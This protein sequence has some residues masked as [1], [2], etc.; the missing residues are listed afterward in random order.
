MTRPKI[1][2][3]ASW[4]NLLNLNHVVAGMWWTWNILVIWY[5]G[6]SQ[7]SM[8]SIIYYCILIMRCLQVAQIHLK[9]P[10]FSVDLLYFVIDISNIGKGTEFFC[11]AISNL[12]LNKWERE[13]L[14]WYTSLQWS[15]WS[16]KRGTKGC[17]R[18]CIHLLRSSSLLLLSSCP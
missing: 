17:F 3:D 2:P 16:G 7:R 1:K 11:A 8:R 15:N 6:Y 14:G 9:K 4:P 18:R 10:P 13:P 12:L 5:K